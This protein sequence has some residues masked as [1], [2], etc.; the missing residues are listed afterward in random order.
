MPVRIVVISDT[1]GMHELLDIPSGDI[2]IHAG[3]LTRRGFQS[4]VVVFNKFLGQL[5][6]P[7]K[8]VVAGNH[9]FCFEENAEE[10]RLLL[11]NA[12]YL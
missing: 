3:D 10:C 5:P 1:H 8:I 4:E 12:I 2:L 9:D 11:T 6:H 7:T